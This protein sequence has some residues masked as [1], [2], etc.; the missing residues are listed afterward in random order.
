MIKRRRTLYG[1]MDRTLLLAAV[2]VALMAIVFLYSATWDRND[3]G[4]MNDMVM[5]QCL[6]VVIGL[7]LLFVMAN[8]DYMNIVN[9]AYVL[10]V[11]SLGALLLL[12]FI[13]STRYGARRWIALG[14][15]SFQPSEFVKIASVLALAA[16]LG[17]RRERA[18]TFGNFIFA[19]ALIAPAFLLIFAQPDL[20]TALVLV[21]ML[22]GMLFVCGE[23]IKYIVGSICL[24]LAG[25]PVFWN[26]LKDYQKTRLLV[27]VNPNL[28][29]L[30]AGY[31]IIQS[32]RAAG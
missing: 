20:G 11:I 18:G 4:I 6:W 23:R 7:M 16:F 17:D 3:P 25:M 27:F 31:T 1:R 22:F 13:G 9:M 5:K 21:P 30:G 29:P 12:F 10:Y 32:R 8:T 14:P 24:G 19:C 15:V 26:V 28:D 2:A